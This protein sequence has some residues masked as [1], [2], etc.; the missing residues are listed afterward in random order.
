MAS[1][2]AQFGCVDARISWCERARFNRG[3]QLKTFLIHTPY[4]LICSLFAVCDRTS[5]RASSCRL[6][7]RYPEALAGFGRDHPIA[8]RTFRIAHDAAVANI[9]AS[10]KRNLLRTRHGL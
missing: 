1:G 5:E 10:W 8:F 2:H 4:W 3:T 7:R 9:R 6:I